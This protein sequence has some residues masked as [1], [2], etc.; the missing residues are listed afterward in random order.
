[1]N[2]AR[3][4]GLPVHKGLEAELSK[5]LSDMNGVIGGNPYFIL[6]SPYSDLMTLKAFSRNEKY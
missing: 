6:A 5:H 4:V 3:E 1:V 2:I